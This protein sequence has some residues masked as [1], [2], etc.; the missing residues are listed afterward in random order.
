MGSHSSQGIA[1]NARHRVPKYVLRGEHLKQA[2]SAI[3]F[4][5]GDVGPADV[6]FGLADETPIDGNCKQGRFYQFAKCSRKSL[7]EVIHLMD[8]V[9]FVSSEEF[10][11]SIASKH[12]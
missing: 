6:G 8:A 10:V 9:T 3:S 5:I 11:S 4:W 12:D 7:V 1:V 2:P